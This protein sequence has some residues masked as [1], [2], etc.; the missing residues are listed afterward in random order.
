M[1]NKTFKKA[2]SLVLAV[3]MTLSVFSYVPLNVQAAPDKAAVTKTQ[4]EEPATEP[5]VQAPVTEEP[6]VE[7][8]VV[9][10]EQ[11]VVTTQVVE[12]TVV[13]AETVV[14]TAANT[15]AEQKVL[16]AQVDGLTFEVSGV[17]NA[18]TVLEVVQLETD[19]NEYIH[20]DILALPE[21]PEGFKG[22]SYD[23]KLMENGVEIQPSADVT[24]TVKDAQTT[25][26]TKVFVYHMEGTSAEDIYSAYMAD[27]GV[28][29]LT[30]NA[31]EEKVITGE[32][33]ENV[34]VT[35]VQTAEDGLEHCC[36]SG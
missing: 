30:A 3:V 13:E 26:E 34:T 12:K 4:T 24:V 8:P 1:K 21:L 6:V 31:A 19:V 25:A 35:D 28:Q 32:E 2:L 10:Q 29:M 5:E 17:F 27:A 14:D 9:E 18:G 33:I 20:N 16:Q 23:I 36:R 22:L 11:P 15:A 7:Q